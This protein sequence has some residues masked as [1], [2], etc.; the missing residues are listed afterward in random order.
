MGRTKRAGEPDPK[1]AP[2]S[3]RQKTEKDLRRMEA[4][5]LA[6]RARDLLAKDSDEEEGQD[7]DK[8][9]DL[10]SEEPEDAD[11]SAAGSSKRKGKDGERVN[12]AEGDDEDEQPKE[13]KGTK[14]PSP[15]TMVGLSSKDML[16][17]DKIRTTH[18]PI[19]VDVAA[20]FNKADAE[21]A[22]A[23]WK[24]PELKTRI[25]GRHAEYRNS[26]EKRKEAFLEKL[27]DRKEKK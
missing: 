8:R 23:K 22:P 14:G 27:K 24:D 6:Q 7:E 26:L 13:G 20:L 15:K 1:G 11:K 21:T 18:H 25:I 3:T 9:S 5:Q 19:V 17:W 10:E 2:P 16:T 4:E 12:D